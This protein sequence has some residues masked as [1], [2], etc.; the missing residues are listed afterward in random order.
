MDTLKVQLHNIKNIKEASIELPFDNGI[1]TFVGTNGCGKS[2]L[3][4][5]LAQL[6]S[7][8]LQRLAS[9]D[10]KSDEAVSK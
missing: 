1:Y 6:L 10:T 2:T 9:S 4:L 8:Q 3:M 7:N 5:C